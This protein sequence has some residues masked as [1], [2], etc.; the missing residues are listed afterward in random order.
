MI[1]LGDMFPRDYRGKMFMCNTHGKR[2]NVDTLE[3]GPRGV[4]G[5]HDPDFLGAADTWLA[6]TEPEGLVR[7]HLAGSIGRLERAARW[8][9][10]SPAPAGPTP[11]T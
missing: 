4:V 8:A 6:T 5:R 11:N 3:H 10:T 9:R 2:V 7:L 1:Y